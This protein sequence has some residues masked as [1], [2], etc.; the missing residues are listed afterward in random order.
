MKSV[1]YLLDL[2]NWKWYS[3]MLLDWKDHSD[4]DLLIEIMD[5]GLEHKIQRMSIKNSSD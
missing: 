4:K 2:L 5:D 3:D 1:A